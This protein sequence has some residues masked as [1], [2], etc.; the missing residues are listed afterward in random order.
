MEKYA[1]LVNAL[2]KYVEKTEI[3]MSIVLK[4]LRINH[5]VYEHKP[6]AFHECGSLGYFGVVFA[7]LN[8]FYDKKL[9]INDTVRFNK[10]PNMK[11]TYVLEAGKSEY[12]IRELIDAVLIRNDTNAGD[13]LIEVMGSVKVNSFLQDE[14]LSH[15][16]VSAKNMSCAMDMAKLLENAYKKRMIV[17]RLCDHVITRIERNRDNSMFNRLIL[18]K[19]NIM[20]FT[21]EMETGASGVCIIRENHTDYLISIQINDVPNPSVAKRHISIVTKMIY[22]FM[23]FE[24]TI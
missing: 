15:T 7:I 22:E 5:T 20:Q 16:R 13:M 3:N 10:R 8:A 12:T 2:N 1:L 14:G 24:E 17:P 4:E 11:V 9:N 23:S 6:N 19:F 18:E 21:G